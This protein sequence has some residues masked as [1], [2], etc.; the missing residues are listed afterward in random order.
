MTLENVKALS[1][2]ELA[3][4]IAWAQEEVKARAEKRKQETI[5]KIKELAGSVGV[6]VAIGGVRGRPSQ[7]RR[8]KPVPTS[9]KR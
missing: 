7:V 3:Q 4:V 1:D 6:R 9:E 5:A 8:G 2:S